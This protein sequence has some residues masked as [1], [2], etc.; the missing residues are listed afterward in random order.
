LLVFVGICWDLVGFVGISMVLRVL[1]FW[2]DFE[3]VI[4]IL[5]SLLD[6]IWEFCL[7]IGIRPRGVA[8]A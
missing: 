3:G 1:V 7:D 5:Q 2:L 8:G 4:C 6:A